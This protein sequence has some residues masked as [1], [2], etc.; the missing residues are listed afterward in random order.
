MPPPTPVAENTG[1]LAASRFYARRMAVAG[2]LIRGDERSAKPA[3]T[4]AVL[5]A[6]VVVAVH[7]VG[8]RSFAHESS[9]GAAPEVDLPVWAS[10]L[11]GG[12]LVLGVVAA[13]T[14]RAARPGVAVGLAAAS[15]GA[16]LPLW[17]SWSGA[18]PL[19]RS[20]VLTAPALVA[21]GLS[22]V[23][24]RWSAGRA[25]LGALAWVSAAAAAAA[26]AV[27]VIAYDPFTDLECA[28]VCRSTVGPWVDASP[29][30]VVRIEGLL[31]LG[32]AGLGLLAIALGRAAPTIIRGWA[33]ASLV[34]VGTAAAAEIVW[35][36]TEAWARTT[37]SW[38][39]W[40]LGP[41]TCAVCVI[42]LRAAR[43][44]RA[45]DALL[46]DLEEGQ[47]V[48][49]HFAVPG[50]DRW[51]DAAGRDVPT[52]TAAV[53]LLHDEHGPAVRL[54]GSQGPQDVTQ[55]S[56][57]RRLALANARLTALATARLADVRAA[58]RR[59]VQRTDTERHR[60]ERDLH[61]G[62]QQTLVS[63]AFHLSAAATRLG[64]SAAI[65]E[66]QQDVTSALARL[67]GLV[68]GL[69]PTVLLEEGL[70]A[71][72]EDLAAEAPVPVTAVTHGADEP[73]TDI[74]I[75]AYLCA[76]ALVGR[77]APEPCSINIEVT[78]PG[79]R[80]VGHSSSDLSDVLGDGVLDR[81]GALD[82]SVTSTRNGLE[83]T[84]EVWLPCES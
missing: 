63:A 59:T 3:A 52:D 55:L 47:P 4:A 32:S 57:S 61:D 20:V 19:L 38:L 36:D 79:V 14:V 71:A 10:L 16:A 62:A 33:G 11:A 58:Q 74:A 60:I 25:R 34:L 73:P 43:M 5:L 65:E 9:P 2:P 17:A 6:T 82:G 26:A 8:V 21:A 77:A 24:P 12:C 29:H 78:K 31:V 41:P 53:V 67:R 83:W 40:A 46:R 66:A 1:P 48:G 13:W 23:V 72:L 28:R 30:T 44:R 15:V 64:E 45:I 84:T 54:E 70:R 39:P 50:E 80:L 35:R 27:H 81:V 7:L 49:L 37:S 76:R 51:V 56:A 68:H 69:V 22:Q 75:A 18:P 42:S